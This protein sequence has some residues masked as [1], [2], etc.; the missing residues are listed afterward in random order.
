MNDLDAEGKLSKQNFVK[1]VYEI[2]SLVGL[3]SIRM[4]D[5]DENDNPM[6]IERMN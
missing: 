1:M 2:L 6:W 3:Y 4:G 5:F